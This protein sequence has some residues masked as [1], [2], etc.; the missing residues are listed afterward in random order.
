MTSGIMDE[1]FHVV[2]KK[3][4]SGR[5]FSSVRIL[6]QTMGPKKLYKQYE[7]PPYP[8]IV[9]APTIRNVL[10]SITKPDLVMAFTISSIGILQFISYHF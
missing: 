1:R 9:Y 4:N 7:R 3:A 2:E 5:W 6:F 8:I 10:S